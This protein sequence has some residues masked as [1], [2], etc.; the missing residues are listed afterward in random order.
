V[1]QSDFNVITW[2]KIVSGVCGDQN[3]RM[4]YHFNYPK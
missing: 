4:S 2:V 1:T 3:A